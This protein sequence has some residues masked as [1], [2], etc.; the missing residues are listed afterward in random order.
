M[1]TLNMTDTAKLFECYHC[2]KIFGLFLQ[3]TVWHFNSY[4]WTLL[5]VYQACLKNL[6]LHKS[7]WWVY[8]YQGSFHHCSL[9]GEFNQIGL[10][11]SSKSFFEE[12]WTN[13]CNEILSL[14]RPIAKNSGEKPFLNELGI[15]VS[16]RLPQPLHVPYSI[17]LPYSYTI[18]SG[19]RPT[20]I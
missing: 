12:T 19:T 2:G 15:R 9:T 18:P 10:E 16:R 1:S 20:S 6:T 7:F 5:P 14:D 17:G 8:S 13:P 4:T 11:S 3:L